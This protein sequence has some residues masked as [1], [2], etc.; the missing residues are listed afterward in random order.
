[1]TVY[2]INYRNRLNEMLDKLIK[3]H[4][5]EDR[6]VVLFATYVEKLE[7]QANYQNREKMEKMF[8]GWMK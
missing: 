3:K 4:G 2:E 5:F 1:M 7:N 6:R 8:K